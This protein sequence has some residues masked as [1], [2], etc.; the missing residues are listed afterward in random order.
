MMAIPNND[1]L[2]PTE[3]VMLKWTK[4]N[5]APFFSGLFNKEKRSPYCKPQWFSREGWVSRP[6]AKQMNELEHTTWLEF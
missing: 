1:W 3:A 4:R 6:T 2:L 5:Q